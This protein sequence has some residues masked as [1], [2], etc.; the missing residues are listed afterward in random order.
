MHV[1]S[2]H[3][4]LF[5]PSLQLTN[6]LNL[7]TSGFFTVLHKS[8]CSRLQEN[9][10]FTSEVNPFHFT[11]VFPLV[12][13]L[14]SQFKRIIPTITSDIF[15]LTILLFLLEDQQRSKKISHM[16]IYVIDLNIPNFLFY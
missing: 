16:T 2:F 10:D 7:R 15:V 6:P 13:K 4:F 14:F 12:H 5:A 3:G 8:Q 9:S 1:K 11:A